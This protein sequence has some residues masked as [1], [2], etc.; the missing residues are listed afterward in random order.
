MAQSGVLRS[1]A[2]RGR[3]PALRP[4]ET[5]DEEKENNSCKTFPFKVSTL[6]PDFPSEPRWRRKRDRDAITVLFPFFLTSWRQ[7]RVF[8]IIFSP[9]ALKRHSPPKTARG[10]ASPAA[11]RC[12]GVTDAIR[13]TFYWRGR[14]KEREADDG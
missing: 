9:V 1:P 13:F 5:K 2:R 12:S 10:V 4:G 11:A 14:K 6:S 8:N 3:L 7:S